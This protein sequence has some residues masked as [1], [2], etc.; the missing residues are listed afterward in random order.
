LRLVRPIPTGLPL[1]ER[2]AR[3]VVQRSRLLEAMS[4]VRRAALLHEPFSPEIA[5]RLDDARSLARRETARVFASELDPRPTPERRILLAALDAATAWPT[6]EVLRRHQ[7]L[8]A[9]QARTVMETM[10]R[11]LLD[12][13]GPRGE[14]HT[15]GG[16]VR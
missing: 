15:N 13:N 7:Q 8:S 3:F 14:S 5:R 1:E 6:W 12:T 16:N 11:A 2:L 4:P 10:L 9:S